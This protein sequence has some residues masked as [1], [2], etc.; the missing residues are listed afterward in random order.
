MRP[1]PQQAS[2]HLSERG[3]G[4]VNST[5]ARRR[6]QFDRRASDDSTDAAPR[7]SEADAILD[8]SR[9]A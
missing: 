1:A 2:D 4:A 6:G 3:A 7:L 9:A 5:G 8:N